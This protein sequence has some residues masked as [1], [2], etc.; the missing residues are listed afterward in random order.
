[1]ISYTLVDLPH[2][3]LCKFNINCEQNKIQQN[4]INL[5]IVSNVIK[6]NTVKKL[7][8]NDE[9]DAT[10]FS[11]VSNNTSVGQKLQTASNNAYSEFVNISNNYEQ[12]SESKILPIY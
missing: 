2:R 7:N 5:P 8:L 11:Y 4:N 9:Y 3:Q 1:M 6:N 10:N 12:I